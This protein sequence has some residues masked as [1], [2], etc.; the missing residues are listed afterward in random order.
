MITE[1]VNE[2]IEKKALIMKE[3]PIIIDNN[4]T[5][6]YCDLWC[7]INKVSNSLLDSSIREGDRVLLIGY[8]SAKWIYVF[9][10]IMNINA[11]PIPV[12]AESGTEELINI[13]IDTEPSAIFF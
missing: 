7:M 11:I 2:L 10:A 12:N 9:F 6:T 3:Y 13:L 5:V 1:T 8:N 4:E